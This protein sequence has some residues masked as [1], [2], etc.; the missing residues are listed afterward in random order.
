MDTV[1]K[2]TNGNECIGN[3][4]SSVRLS[5]FIARLASEKS[6]ITVRDTE[7]CRVEAVLA[8][9][10]RHC[11]A[12]QNSDPATARSALTSPSVA[13]ALLSKH[14]PRGNEIGRSRSWMNLVMSTLKLQSGNCV[15]WRHPKKDGPSCINRCHFPNWIFCRSHSMLS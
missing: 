10:G 12:T 15:K 14:H 13:S 8:S 4:T 7:P 2:L 5:G 9:S 1:R 11:R 3:P 6:F